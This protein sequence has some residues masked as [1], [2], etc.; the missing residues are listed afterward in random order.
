MVVLLNDETAQSQWCRYEWDVAAE[1]GLPTK[2]L[3]DLERCSGATKQAILNEVLTEWPH[4]C[5]EQWCD[6]TDRHRRES[7]AEVCEFLSDT[8]ERGCAADEESFVDEENALRFGTGRD[9]QRL[10][11]PWFEATCLFAGLRLRRDGQSRW[12]AK[13]STKQRRN[14]RTQLSSSPS[15]VRSVSSDTLLDIVRLLTMLDVIAGLVFRRGPHWTGEPYSALSTLVL[16]VNLVIMPKIYHKIIYGRTFTQIL[17]RMENTTSRLACERVHRQTKLVAVVIVLATLPTSLFIY[18]GEVALHFSA[19]YV[20]HAHFAVRFY[21]CAGGVIWAVTAIALSWSGFVTLGVSFV[22][23]R[24]SVVQLEA[25]FDSLHPQIA[26]LGLDRYLRVSGRR[27]TLKPGAL[28]HFHESWAEGHEAYKKMQHEM[29]AIVGVV[30]VFA[31]SATPIA[32][33][34]YLGNY[35]FPRSEPLRWL[36]LMRF[37]LIHVIGVVCGIAFPVGIPLLASTLTL[38]RLRANASRLVCE[39]A[40]HWCQLI[41]MMRQTDLTCYTLRGLLPATPTVL[42]LV[43]VVGLASLAPYLHMLTLE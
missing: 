16:L 14:S 20:N 18:G 3:L 11:H 32:C 4:L 36:T 2:V 7:I 12:F 27:L 38:R 39:D 24:L 17:A 29:D 22:I 35:E 19:F 15:R 9:A 34:L 30:A 43:S 40:A 42:A 13:G 23:M 8:A 6:Y 31:L 33:T 5:T 10:L 37:L 28:A 41:E 21:G 25:A 1:L 26:T